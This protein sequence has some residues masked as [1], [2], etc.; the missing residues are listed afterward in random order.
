VNAS[1]WAAQGNGNAQNTAF[2]F[3]GLNIEQS[4]ELSDANYPMGITLVMPQGTTALIDW[5]PKQ[6]RVGYG[7]YNSYL[8]G[9]GSF[10]D[11]YGTKA[12]FA[13]H[14]YALRS[15]TSGTNGIQQDNLM[16][17]EISVD[18]AQALTP[19]SNAN[20]SPVYEVAQL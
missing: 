9:Y 20:E 7:D 15:D 19:F 11:P 17:F 2:Q 14:A 1:F 4:V 13:V 10:K 18:V 3:T 16:Q 8:G 12:T 5:I 6:N